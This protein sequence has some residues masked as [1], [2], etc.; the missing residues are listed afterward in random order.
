VYVSTQAEVESLVAHLSASLGGVGVGGYH[1][2]MPPPARE[3]A[4]ARFMAGAL[5]VVVATV[6]FG[7]G[8]DKPDLRLVIHADPP[9]SME[10]YLQQ[11][12]RAGRDGDPALCLA[13]VDA[14]PR[15]G[16]PTGE[17]ARA[18][19][20][21]GGDLV[22]PAVVHGVLAYLV[23]VIQHGAAAAAAACPTLPPP[24]ATTMDPI[25]FPSAAVAAALNMKVETVETLLYHV[26]DVVGSS[27]GRLAFTGTCARTGEVQVSVCRD[28]WLV[29]TTSG[30]GGGERRALA[31]CAP[32]LLRLLAAVAAAPTDTGRTASG[33]AV[34][35]HRDGRG[36]PAFVVELAPAAALLARLRATAAEVSVTGGPA[37]LASTVIPLAAGGGRLSLGDAAGA[38]EPS[39]AAILRHLFTMQAAGD[40]LLHFPPSSYGLEA[41]ASAPATWD[42]E[43]PA[44]ARAVTARM[45]GV[46]TRAM[47][48]VAGVHAAL[49][50]AALPSWQ[51]VWGNA[52][53][54]ESG[55][56]G[57]ADA[58]ASHDTLAAALAAHLDA[59]DDASAADGGVDDMPR[60]PTLPGT[61]TL[62]GAAAASARASFVQ[63]ALAVAR[64]AV[65]LLEVS[66]SS[67]GG[68]AAGTLPPLQSWLLAAQRGA[69]AV[70]WRHPALTPGAIVRVLMG[71]ASPSLSPRDFR[72]TSQWG[73]YGSHA[74]HELWELAC[75]VLRTQNAADAD[76][77]HT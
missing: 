77:A 46:A 15:A 55:G 62:L 3:A 12:G 36:R 16:G 38:A 43:L 59:H 39:I 19:A 52:G 73:R 10:D 29:A 4:Y 54:V 18:V 34:G 45:N 76:A 75:G 2:G 61:P 1:A 56:G 58:A 68:G 60:A 13:F 28:E 33:C 49:T 66:D 31:P 72:G 47:A 37:A 69:G 22:D 65:E 64:R 50:A 32:P 51:G 71:V 74:W 11:V 8:I 27:G 48:R 42:G 14:A 63:D 30:G 7:M 24:P 70:A 67:A 20:L 35:M 57:V 26:E 40:L 9:R 6:A 17:C 44:L 23:R 41:V 25:V 5:R 21:T 53:G